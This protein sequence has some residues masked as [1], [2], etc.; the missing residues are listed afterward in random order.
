MFALLAAS[1]LT[2]R[3]CRAVNVQRIY[4]RATFDTAAYSVGLFAVSMRFNLIDKYL[5]TL[6][7]IAVKHPPLATLYSPDSPAVAG[8]D[9]IVY[10]YVCVWLCVV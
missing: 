4:M 8:W 3:W 7:A 2:R 1:S 5:N 6:Y 9:E 10:L